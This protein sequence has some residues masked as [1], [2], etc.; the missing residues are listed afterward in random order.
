MLGENGTEQF[1]I[2]TRVDGRVIKEQP[3]HDP[4]LHS[5]T[6]VGISRWDLFKALFKKQFEVTVEISVRGSEGI[7]RAIMMLDP[8]QLEAETAAIL[9]ERRRSRD[10]KR[11]QQLP[12]TLKECEGR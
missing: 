11:G 7:Q 12:A 10:I 5:K 2:K 9:D 6:V 4:F 3:I 8:K 1:V